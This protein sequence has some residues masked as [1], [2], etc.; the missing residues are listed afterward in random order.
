M[1]AKTDQEP[2]PMT[3]KP[4]R[5]L[6]VDDEFSVRDSLCHWFRKEGYEVH[7]GGRGRGS[8]QGHGGAP[9]RTSPC[10]TSSWAGWT[11]WS[12]RSTS[13]ASPLRPP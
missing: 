7:G 6:I 5:I 2:A 10:W 8:L 11:A 3:T 1:L 13:I 12:S 4:A 9:V